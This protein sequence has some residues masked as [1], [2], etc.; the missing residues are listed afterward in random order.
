MKWFVLC[1]TLALLA[2]DVG[3]AEAAVGESFA[4]RA[5]KAPHTLA[6]DPSMTDP[7]W[8]AG[9]IP[10]GAWQNVTT[11]GQAGQ[12]TTAYLLY[13][14]TYL[15]VGF[16]ASQPSDP[17]VATQSTNDVGFGSD[18]FVAAGVD[19]SSNGSQAY[20]FET[21]PRATRY[22]QAS[23]N[24]RFRP[25]WEAAA[26]VQSGSWNAVMRIPLRVLRIRSGATTWHVGFFRNV[27]ARGEHLTWAFDPTMQDLPAGSWPYFGDVRFWPALT[28]VTPKLLAA[29][30]KPRVEV[31][32]LGSVGFE[33]N[34]YQQANG[35][36]APERTRYYGL[37][38][39]IP[40]AATINLV[41]T[42][43]PDFSNVEI[44]QQTIAP[45]EFPR[46]LV[47]YR[48]F[49]AQ[50]ASYVSMPISINFN[51]PPNEVFY[52]PSIGPFDSGLKTE[53][54]FG[55][56]SFGALT[57]RG[58]DETT[59]NTFDD[60][61]F[62]YRH[63]LAGQTFQYWLDGVLAH[64]SIAGTDSTYEGG[65]SGRDLSTGL[66]WVINGD[67]EVGSWVPGGSASALDTRVAIVKP[68]YQAVMGYADLSPEYD[69]IDGFTTI[70]DIRGFAGYVNLNGS[71]KAIKNW[72]LF[73][74]GDR[75]NDATG[76]VHEAD[77]NVF[78]SAVF[79]NGFSINGLGPSTSELRGY[80]GNFFTGYPSYA[81]PSTV[82][83]NLFG[84]PIGYRDGTPAPID[85][86]V[87]WGSFGGNW[88]HYYSIVTSRPAGK[89]FSIGLEYDASYQRALAAGTL[90]S[91]FLR[92]ISIGFNPNSA[93][94]LTIGLRDVNGLGGFSPQEGSNLAAGF[95]W[96]LRAGDLYANY[97]SPA[98]YAT[99]DR[100]IVKFVLR[101]GGDAGT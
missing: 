92:R 7:A 21:T 1:G 14:D 83:F 50:G 93:I 67:A 68:N 48:P 58:F 69:P 43:N 76:A 90:D 22:Q 46:Q 52:S 84:V 36:F 38:F 3:S 51:S 15:Y 62:G 73:V 89:R 81:R 56:Q 20:F 60:Q 30:P 13:D 27:A 53:G 33:R 28:N 42:A 54:T 94:N 9:L 63:V 80:N 35:T 59:G 31:F 72:A 82:P 77:S 17:I 64:H 45:Q 29:K 79:K 100:F 57:F 101:A 88:Q 87:Q 34:V 4:F 25:Q 78:L 2:A 91:Q 74:Q 41:G 66:Q 95:H 85:A 16:V 23:E 5:V 75:F 47:E 61:V 32:A 96:R 37:D 10:G 44:D 24:V 18:D 40:L 11:R 39:S 65:A 70:A 19:P 99:L 8:K 12:T 71:T 97:G 55:L 26:S 6:L 86:T 49:F 98:A